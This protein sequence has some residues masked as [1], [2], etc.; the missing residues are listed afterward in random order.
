MF[1]WVAICEGQTWNNTLP[2]STHQDYYINASGNIV[3][4][5]SNYY[6]IH[7]KTTTYLTPEVCLWYNTILANGGTIADSLV[8]FINEFDI[9][10]RPYRWHFNRFNPYFGSNLKAISVPLYVSPFP[11]DV[12]VLGYN[13]DSLIGF[14]S[15]DYTYSGTTRGL[16][17]AANKYLN[18]GVVPNNVSTLQFDYTGLYLGSVT[19]GGSNSFD[20][21]SQDASA[22]TNRL[23]IRLRSSTNVS[24]GYI[25]GAL[26]GAGRNTNGIGLYMMYSRGDSTVVLKN[27]TVLSVAKATYECKPNQPIYVQGRNTGSGL[28][29][30]IRR[31]HSYGILGGV[32]DDNTAKIIINEINKLQKKLGI[33][34]F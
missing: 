12:L 34:G 16:Q 24:Q 7:R 13:I 9:A 10:V 25:N 5:T 33:T 28:E 15:A 8:I 19:S 17:S 29:T 21:G 26:T 14:D 2:C 23:I 30:S 6:H 22:P 31:I 20:M 3:K 4:D 11:R 27:S 1:F 32:P 18:T